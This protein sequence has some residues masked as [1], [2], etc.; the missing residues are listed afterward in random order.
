MQTEWSNSP[1]STLNIIPFLLLYYQSISSTPRLYSLQ[2]I[3]KNMHADGLKT[4]RRISACHSTIRM[5]DVLLEFSFLDLRSELRNHLEEIIHDT[6][7]SHLEDGCLFVFVDGHYCLAVLHARQVLN[8]TADTHLYHIRPH[9]IRSHHDKEDTEQSKWLPVSPSVLPPH[10]ERGPPLCQ[11]GRSAAR[12]VRSQ[13]PRRLWMLPLL[14]RACRQ[15][16]PAY[17]SFPLLRET[18][19]QSGGRGGDRVGWAVCSDDR[20]GSSYRSS[21]HVLRRSPH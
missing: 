8:G 14:L 15:E 3:R 7:I 18:D 20:A 5:M 21:C 1:S 16:S 6:I 13:H 10:T 19:R 4:H 9:H 11:S 2:H 12:W 17:Q